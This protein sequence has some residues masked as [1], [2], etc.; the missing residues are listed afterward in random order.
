MVQRLR[1]QC[2]NVRGSSVGSPH[3]S[4]G[5]AVGLHQSLQAR[6][7]SRVR[8]FVASV[9]RFGW[10]VLS[11]AS[12]GHGELHAMLQ[13]AYD[14]WTWE[15]AS[16][17]L[18]ALAL[19]GGPPLTAPL[20]LAMQHL[21]TSGE[22]PAR[23]ALQSVFLGTMRTQSLEWWEHFFTGSQLPALLSACGLAVAQMLQVPR[24]CRVQTRLLPGLRSGLM[25]RP[26]AAIGSDRYAPPSPS[27]TNTSSGKCIQRTGEL[28]TRSF[29]D[30]N[31]ET[32]TSHSGGM[33]E[34][35]RD[36]AACA[37]GGTISLW[38]LQANELADKGSAPHPRVAQVEQSYNA[39]A[40][41][42]GWLA[43]FLGRLHA[44]VKFRGWSDLAPRVHR[45][46]RTLPG[47]LLFFFSSASREGREPHTQS[48]RAR[49]RWR[50]RASFGSAGGAGSA[51]H[52]RRKGLRDGVAES[53]QG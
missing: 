18:P 48:F 35:P 25:A 26:N 20:K 44:N 47:K 8:F 21:R 39:R 46:R 4:I 19:V 52:K 38:Q 14:R 45:Q 34:G 37:R 49:T 9:M 42:L 31:L 1:F 16:D 13:D 43:K 11:F 50:R 17:R 51:P 27:G 23:R 10:R 30:V 7:W 40:L 22:H 6:E 12:V 28:D 41:F 5:Q 33:G 29:G 2:G 15:R 53:W 32:R 36:G 24:I 3:G